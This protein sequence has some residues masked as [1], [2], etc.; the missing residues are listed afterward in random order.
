MFRP[1]QGL[2]LLLA[3]VIGALVGAAPAGAAAPAGPGLSFLDAEFILREG[4]IP[5]APEAKLFA[6]LVSTDANGN[7]LRPLLGSSSVAGIGPRV[8]WSADGS[9]FAFVGEPSTSESEE[10]RLYLARADGSGVHAIPGTNG[11]SD[12]VLSSDGSLLAYSLTRE[13][14]PKF[15][16]KNLK[17]A[18]KALHKS[19]SSSTTW[20]VPIAGGKP[21]RLTAWGKER[22]SQPSSI[23]PDGSTLAVTVERPGSNPE[24]DAVDLATGKV[25]TLEV[26]G[27]DAAYSPDGSAIAFVSY[28]DHESV[29]GFDEREAVSELYVAAADGTGAHR[30]THTPHMQE[31]APSWDPSGTRLAYLRSPGGGLGVLEQ[32]IVESNGDGT[33]PQAIELPPAQH[34]GWETLI[35]TPTWVPGEGRGVGPLSCQ[36]RRGRAR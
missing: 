11:A 7:D 23:S 1:R 13:H 10:R 29:P 4:K 28:R 20:I 19:W 27:T 18:L 26:N 33:C 6:Q 15:N 16:P 24:V 9:E 25:R 3:L 30:I 34:K 14:R 2:P 31:G 17:S 12:P 8:A 21:R 5:D 35:G 22:H 32:G 36:A